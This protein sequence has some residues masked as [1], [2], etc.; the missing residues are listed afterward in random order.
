MSG[1]PKND[2]SQSEPDFEDSL[3]FSEIEEPER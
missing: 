1:K 2:D 3:D